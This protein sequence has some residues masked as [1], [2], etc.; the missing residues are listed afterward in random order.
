MRSVLALCITEAAILLCVLNRVHGINEADTEWTSDAQM[1]AI[2]ALAKKYPRIVTKESETDIYRHSTSSV[3]ERLAH[4]FSFIIKPDKKDANHT[5]RCDTIVSRYRGQV[6]SF[7]F[8][9]PTCYQVECKDE[10]VAPRKP[11]EKICRKI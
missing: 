5:Y 11:L 9:E 7:I 6:Y 10:E 3:L 1:I 8:G 4:S 2:D